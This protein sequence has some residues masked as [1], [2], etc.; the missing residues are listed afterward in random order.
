MLFTARLSGYGWLASYNLGA[1]TETRLGPNRSSAASM[2]FKEWR[3]SWWRIEPARKKAWICSKSEPTRQV[4]C[5]RQGYS[6]GRPRSLAVCCLCERVVVL[7][8]L[9]QPAGYYVKRTT[10]RI[11]E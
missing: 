11:D 8:D 6:L 2:S 5:P 9:I 7:A 10:L 3:L 1:S 4:G